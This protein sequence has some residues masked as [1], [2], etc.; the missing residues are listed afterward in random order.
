MEQRWFGVVIAKRRRVLGLS[1][2]AV[3]HAAGI[4]TRYYADIERGKR[5]VSIVV[6]RSIAR[7]IETS[8]QDILNAVDESSG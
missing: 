4:S 3:A 2:E 6:G 1:Q 5:S 7:A 8:L